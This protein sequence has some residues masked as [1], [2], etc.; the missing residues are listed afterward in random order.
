MIEARVHPANR[1]TSGGVQGSERCNC[2]A[3]KQ[4]FAIACK[5]C[6]FLVPKR[7]RQR[8]FDAPKE[9]R[10]RRQTLL[11]IL[12]IVRRPSA[13]KPERPKR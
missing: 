11:E 9:S 2:G 1:V 13:P 6:W 8:F 5:A 12:T 3:P 10:E 4:A 7:L